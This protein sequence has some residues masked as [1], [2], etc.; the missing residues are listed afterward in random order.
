MPVKEW[1]CHREE[2]VSQQ[3]YIKLDIKAIGEM[4]QIFLHKNEDPSVDVEHPHKDASGCGSST[5]NS[6]VTGGRRSSTR[7]SSLTQILKVFDG[8]AEF[9]TPLSPRC[10]HARFCSPAVSLEVDTIGLKI[11]KVQSRFYIPPVL[12]AIMKQVFP[13]S[14]HELVSNP[15]ESCLSI[16]HS[17]DFDAGAGI[18]LND[19]FVKLSSGYDQ[20]CGY[21]SR[22]VDFMVHIASEK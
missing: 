20:E 7:I 4:A 6:S 19:H 17:S 1:T 18:A 22:T 21:S 13:D 11:L 15:L 12:H 10:P 16:I 3:M 9:Y 8:K 5:Y 14:S 2:E